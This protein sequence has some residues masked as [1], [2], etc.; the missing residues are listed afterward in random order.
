MAELLKTSD[1]VAEAVEKIARR[2]VKKQSQGGT[3]CLSLCGGGTPAPIYRALAERKEID[4]Q[5]VIITFGDERCVGPEHDQSNF[6]MAKAALLDP[7]DIPARNVVR[8]EGELDPEEAAQKCEQRLRALAEERGEDLFKHDLILLGM[9]EDGHTASLFPGSKALSESARWV[10][11][12]FVASQDSWRLTITYPLIQA[13]E[14]VFFLIKGEKKQAIVEEI[15]GG[16]SDY[17]AAKVAPMS[18]RLTWIEG[19]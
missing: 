14:E 3:F 4:W 11:E 8:M 10:S 16:G 1:F 15:L 17:P 19:A 5:K 6:R 2:I 9:G 13:A 18:G 7:A 12:N